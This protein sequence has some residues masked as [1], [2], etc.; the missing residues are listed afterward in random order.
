[1]TE[2][3]PLNMRKS[4]Y[5]GA[6]YGISAWLIYGIIEGIFSIILPWFTV[7]HYEYEQLHSGFTVILFILYPIIGIIIGGLSG[8]A[9][10]LGVRLIPFLQKTQS[11]IIFPLAALFTIVLVF[12]VNLVANNS[13][14]LGLSELPPLAI[15]LFLV[16]FLVLSSVS[17]RMFLRFRFVTNPWTASILLIGLPWLNSQLFTSYSVFMKAVG[18]LLFSV[19]ILLISMFI[20]NVLERRQIHR[21]PDSI[22]TISGKSFVL[23]IP[24][25]F[26]VFGMNVFFKQTPLREDLNI[27]AS[28]LPADEPNVILIVM[29]TVRADHLSLYGYERDTTPNLEKFAEEAI[30]Y[31][32]DISPSDTTLSSHGSIFTGLYPRKHGAHYG[33]ANPYGRQLDQKF[34]TLAE[35]LAN[36]GYLTIGIAA[37]VGVLGSGFGLDQGFQYYNARRHVPLLKSMEPYYIRQ[38]LQNFFK[39]YVTPEDF[40][41]KCRTA[42]AINKEVFSILDQLDGKAPFFLFINYM[43]AHEP[44]IPPHP[45]DR[46]YPGKDNRFTTKRYRRLANDVMNFKRSTSEKERDHL[47]SQ[48]DGGIAYVDFHI[49][50]LIEKLKSFPSYQNALIIITSD[51]GEAFGERNLFSHGISVYQDQINVPLIV[52]YPNMMQGHKVLKFV[53]SID[54]MPTVLDVLGYELTGAIDGQSLLN[55]NQRQ[56]TDI[57]SESYPS[58]SLLKGYTQFNRIERALISDNYKFIKSTAGKRELYNI[59]NDPDEKNNLFRSKEVISGKLD[60]KLDKWLSDTVVKH[61][62]PTQHNK[63]ELDRLKAL[64]YI[65]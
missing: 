1:L 39:P 10:Y 27:K 57:V 24:L 14:S 6:I 18:A 44:Y 53:S 47:I 48:Y 11:K 21:S 36:R 61:E 51:H 35:I 46:R 17:D 31:S 3:E 15:S 45:F 33:E 12:D 13:G 40:D 38:A 34:L 37:N 59:S 29:D 55:I 43:D 54:I 2:L 64:G 52:K 63:Y 56:K 9:I 8:Y 7:P 20:Y 62:S 26:L 19:I 23:L 65:K 25:V 50:K 28:S 30:V 22:G 41:R 60:E 58:E 49:G 5:T 42:E 4:I 16:C 32:N